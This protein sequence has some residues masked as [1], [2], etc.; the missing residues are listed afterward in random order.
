MDIPAV[1]HTHSCGYNCACTALHPYALW[2]HTISHAWLCKLHALMRSSNG[3]VEHVQK[4]DTGNLERVLFQRKKWFTVVQTNTIIGHDRHRRRF[5]GKKKKNCVHLGTFGQ[6]EAARSRML[7]AHHPAQ[8]RTVR[9]NARARL[10]PRVR[11]TT[12]SSKSAVQTGVFI[13]HAVWYPISE[14]IYLGT[15]LIQVPKKKRSEQECSLD[16]AFVG[17]EGNHGTGSKG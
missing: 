13:G 4:V 14:P 6:M 12:R 7:L 17:H 15:K 10:Y 5:P 16:K 3:V 9:L 11:R 2:P 8:V 1:T